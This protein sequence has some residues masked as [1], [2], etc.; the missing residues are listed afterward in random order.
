M[1]FYYQVNA[2]PMA[3]A[4]TF[5]SEE[6]VNKYPA[7]RVESLKN[8]F[9][10]VNK[11]KKFKIKG[12]SLKTLLMRVHTTPFECFHGFLRIKLL[13]FIYRS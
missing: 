11:L 6:R 9:R 7:E 12:L 4:E 1:Y 3:Y 8:V 5:L 2:G 10:L 13:Y